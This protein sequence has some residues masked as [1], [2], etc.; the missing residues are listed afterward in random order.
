M[1]SNYYCVIMAGGIGS[2][3]WP[4]SRAGKPKQFLDVLG[5]GRTF[6]QSTFDRFKDIIPPC[7]FFVVT[8]ERYKSMVLEQLPLLDDYQILCEPLRRNTA[9]CITYAASKISALNPDATMIVTPA[10]HLIINSTEFAQVMKESLTFAETHDNLVTVGIQPSRPETGYGYIQVDN[11]EPQIDGVNK[12]KTFTEKP[13]LDM[14]K[15]FLNSGEFFWNS[16]IF[17]WSAKTILAAIQKY[18]PDVFA[19]FDAGSQFYNTPKEAD[20]INALYP[21]CENISIDYGVM[22]K[23]DNVYVR[24]ADFGWSDIGTWDSLYLHSDTSAD[25]NMVAGNAKLYSTR[26]SIVKGQKD[27]LMVVQGLNNYIVI[28][29]EDVLMICNRDQ[30]QTIR[31][32]V[33]D[34]KMTKGEEFI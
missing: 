16:G 5:T 1:E 15:I 19:Q 33:D 3:F 8:N 27:K 25:S 7:N 26:N 28:D 12:V 32:W 2:R 23:A 22:E 11:S 21:E 29:T 30:E 34:I 6:L 9:P 4:L 13:N 14:A 24:C 31:C 10:D 18:M 17:V 20:F